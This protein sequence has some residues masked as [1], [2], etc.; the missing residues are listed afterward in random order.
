[1]NLF[2]CVHELFFHVQEKIG[3]HDPKQIKC[4]SCSSSIICSSC[5]TKFFSD[6]SAA[7][8]LSLHAASTS[9]YSWAPSGAFP[10][11]R[12]DLLVLCPSPSPAFSP[13]PSSSSSFPLLQHPHRYPA[14]MYSLCPVCHHALFRGC[15]HWRPWGSSSHQA[16]F[17]LLLACWL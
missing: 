6:V 15:P 10:A 14:D 3:R 5:S 2:S 4:S 13:L 8:I 12:S 11:K 9:A 1:M 17:L 7:S 16:A